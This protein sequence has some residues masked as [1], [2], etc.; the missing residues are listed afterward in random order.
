MKL[1]AI[2]SMKLLVSVVCVRSCFSAMVTCMSKRNINFG[3]NGIC[4]VHTPMYMYV[5]VKI[6]CPLLCMYMYVISVWCH[7]VYLC[8]CVCV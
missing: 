4:N 8:V 5:H 6:A 3:R 7:C 2:R 1:K